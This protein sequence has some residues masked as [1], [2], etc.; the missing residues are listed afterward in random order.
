MPARSLAKPS[1]RQNASN[2]S[3]MTSIGGTFQPI[4]TVIPPGQRREIARKTGPSD[5]RAR[6]GISVYFSGGLRS[7]AQGCSLPLRRG[8][9][10]RRRCFPFS[11]ASM[12]RGGKGERVVR[13]SATVGQCHKAGRAYHR[14]TFGSPSPGLPE[15]TRSPRPSC[16]QLKVET[17]TELNEPANRYTFDG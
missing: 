3:P 12:L 13:L 1:L 2:T 6:Y 11:K 14:I 8:Q 7:L 4:G 9:I 16:L 17:D 15:Q 10:R 5:E